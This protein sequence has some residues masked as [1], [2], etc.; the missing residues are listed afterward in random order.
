[1]LKRVPER[2][3]QP[4]RR[5]LRSQIDQVYQASN[6]VEKPDEATGGPRADP[7]NRLERTKVKD[8]PPTRNVQKM[9]EKNQRDFEKSLRQQDDRSLQDRLRKHDTLRADTRRIMINTRAR[10][11]RLSGAAAN[12]EV[13]A[14]DAKV[15]RIE[16]QPSLIP[17]YAMFDRA[18]R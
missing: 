9:C 10:I 13:A 8:F 4:P 3:L 16:E 14:H 18:S 2:Q 11:P 5:L 6:V 15:R 1:M 17:G 7:V 12:T